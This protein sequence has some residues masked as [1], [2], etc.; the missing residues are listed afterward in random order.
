M[1]PEGILWETKPNKAS[2]DILLGFV[3]LSPTY[4][5]AASG[6]GIKPIEIESL[7]VNLR[8]MF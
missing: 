5:F 4:C 2:F 6:R 1:K 3:S 8:F 7:K